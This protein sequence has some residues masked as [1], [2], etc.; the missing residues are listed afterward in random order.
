[1][2][3]IHTYLHTLYDMMN[4]PCLITDIEVQFESARYVIIE[5]SGEVE[6]TVKTDKVFEYPFTVPIVTV[7][8]NANCTYICGHFSVY[9]LL[10]F[11]HMPT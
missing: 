10:L 7:D 11:A 3:G 1:M 9:L 6:L 2:L 5:D 8:G 4:A